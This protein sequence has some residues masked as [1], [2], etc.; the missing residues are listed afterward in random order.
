MSR[1]KVQC[2]RLPY[3]TLYYLLP[4]GPP[5]VVGNLTAVQDQCTIQIKWEPPYLIPGLD[6]AYK[7]YINGELIQDNITTTSYTFDPDVT[8]STVYNISVAA[9]NESVGDGPSINTMVDFNIDILC[10]LY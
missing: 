1:L 2:H 10:K 9:Y 5:S 3:V 6:V 8:S 7:V 4:I